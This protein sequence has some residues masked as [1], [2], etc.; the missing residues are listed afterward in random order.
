M[1]LTDVRRDGDG[2]LEDPEAWT[3]EFAQLVAEDEGLGYTTDLQEVV[4]WA[5]ASYANSGSAPTIREFG[6]GF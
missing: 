2:F 4:Q 1:K 5:T 6:K 3:P